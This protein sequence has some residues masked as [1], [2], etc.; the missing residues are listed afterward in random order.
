MEAGSRSLICGARLRAVYCDLLNDMA[1]L[2]ALPVSISATTISV[3][4]GKFYSIGPLETDL[5]SLI[6]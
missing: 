5:F 6:C 2:V 4:V 3:V 1:I